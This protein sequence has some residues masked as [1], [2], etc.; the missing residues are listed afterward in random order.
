MS[1]RAFNSKF[2]QQGY[3]IVKKSLTDKTVDE[4][5]GIAKEKNLVGYYSLKKDELIKEIEGD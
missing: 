1:K 3:K 5:R 4:L 2:K